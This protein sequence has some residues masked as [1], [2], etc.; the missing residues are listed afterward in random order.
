MGLNESFSHVRSDLLLKSEVPS[1][2]QAYAIVIQEEN[3][4]LLGV[5]D[6]N[7]EPL[8]MMAGRGQGQ[9]FKGKKVLPG[10]GNTGCEI[11][12][13]KNHVTEKCYRL[14]GYPSDFKSKRK[15]S[16]SSGSYQNNSAGFKSPGSYSSNAYNN[17]GNFK[18][19]AN[20]A[21][22]DKQKQDFEFTKEEYN[23][24][25]N[26]LHNK[27]PSDC[28]ANLIGS[29]AQ[30]N[31]TGNSV[32]FGNQ[33][34]KDVLHELYSGKV[35]GI[36][37]E[38]YGLYLLQRANR[39]ISITDAILTH[40]WHFGLGNPS[41]KVVRTDNGT[42]LFNSKSRALMFHSEMPIRFWGNCVKTISYLNN[43]MPTT[44]LQGKSPYE[45]LYK[46]APNLEHLRVFG[47]QCFVSVLPRRDKLS[48]R[49]KRSVFIGYLETQKGYKVMDLETHVIF[50]SREVT[51][52]ETSFPLKDYIT[53]EVSSFTDH[54]VPIQMDMFDHADVNI[55]QSFVYF[56]EEHVSP[57]YSTVEATLD[58][59]I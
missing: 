41:I 50:V 40:L 45:L 31:H 35:I 8:T 44:V 15:Q 39:A 51:F 58:N 25:K 6:S 18:P 49:A 56:V 21:L 16:D 3:Q 1:I 33:T 43:R 52:M 26:L 20:N 12:G 46:R 47:C 32:I 23:Q 53:G 28:K 48:P 2:N 14:V 10:N 29:R 19:Y 42:D 54:N 34:V 38:V 17:T 24:I 4:R 9:G 57:V 55:S 36:G 13:F 59:P 30:V 5:V 37:K 7:K 11:C 22:V 27:E